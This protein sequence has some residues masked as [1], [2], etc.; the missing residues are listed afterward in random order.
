[1]GIYI[2]LKR[3]SAGITDHEWEEVYKETLIALKNYPFADKVLA[4]TYRGKKYYHADQAK[5]RKLTPLYEGIGWHVFGDLET[6]QYAESFI[7]VVDNNYYKRNEDA[8]EVGDILECITKDKQCATIWDSKTQGEPYHIPLLAIACLIEDRLEG[9]VI[10]QGNIRKFEVEEACR[11]IN[12]YMDKE[13]GYPVISDPQKLITRLNKIYS[14]TQEQL[15]HFYDLYIDV[16]DDEVR[17]VLEQVLGRDVLWQYYQEQLGKIE[18]DTKEFIRLAEQ[19]LKIGYTLEEVAD[20]FEHS[21]ARSR[22]EVEA[23]IRYI[24]TERISVYFLPKKEVYIPGNVEGQMVF[25]LDAL[26]GYDR[27]KYQISEEERVELGHRLKSIFPQYT[28]SIED[29]TEEAIE[30]K[31]EKAK[32]YEEYLGGLNTALEQQRDRVENYDIVAS[33]DLVEWEKGD[34]IAPDI[35]SQLRQIVELCK[36][37]DEEVESMKEV[38]QQLEDSDKLEYMLRDKSSKFLLPKSFW[39]YISENSDN[40]NVLMVIVNLLTID[41]TSAKHY[42]LVKYILC[43]PSLIQD[44]IVEEIEECLG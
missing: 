28:R 14:K 12:K 10:V 41:V 18:V 3:A 9:K 40:D 43:N 32:R 30:G 44:Y 23:F 15:K 29:I 37:K 24:L 13:V 8:E 25:M 16:L 33:Y 26:W 7:L 42:N 4:K 22:G 38:I 34:T 11:W 5:E 1:M 27:N 2:T 6:C 35:E 31:K 20:A 39:E 17:G 19:M 36:M 21:K